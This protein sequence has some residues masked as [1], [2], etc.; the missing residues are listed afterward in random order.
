MPHRITTLAT[1]ATMLASASACSTKRS[2]R[3]DV[4][5]TSG[6]IEKLW[7]RARQTEARTGRPNVQLR[8]DD[9][10]TDEVGLWAD[11]APLSRGN[12]RAN[13]DTVGQPPR[14]LLYQT[15]FTDESGSFAAGS[16]T[17]PHD[18]TSNIDLL[19]RMLK[20]DPRSALVE[21]ESD[22]DTAGSKEMSDDLGAVLAEAVKR[23]LHETHRIP[24]Q[25]M[26]VIADGRDTPTGPSPGRERHARHRRVVIRVFA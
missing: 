10:K 13:A 16:V 1:I 5:S 15:I 26:H 18:A 2:I 3:N 24:L 14:E 21:I 22:S 19:I 8:Q 9:R 20:A 7:D 6:R 11:D 12:A 23:Y 25:K 17:L 4:Y